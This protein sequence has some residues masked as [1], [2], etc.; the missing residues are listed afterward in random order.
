M[1]LFASKTIVV[2]ESNL[3]PDS[4]STENPGLISTRITTTQNIIFS[5]QSLVEFSVLKNLMTS[6]LTFVGLLH[7]G[8]E[9]IFWKKQLGLQAAAAGWR[10]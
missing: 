9:N 3:N 8:S 6:S 7:Y 1:Q 4:P 10:L 2:K 5:N